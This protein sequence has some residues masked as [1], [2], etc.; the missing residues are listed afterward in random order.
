V[1]QRVILQAG[2]S[3][4][5]VPYATGGGGAPGEADWTTAL[6]QLLEE[7]LT[8]WDIKVDCVG[9]WLVTRNG[10][11]TELD[12]PLE[13]TTDADLFVSIHYDAP[14]RR[15][16]VWDA[17]GC[18]ADRATLDPRAADADRFIRIWERIY[19]AGTGIGLD[20]YRGEN[21]PNT[22]NYYAFR[23]TTERT[24]GVI[25]EH[26]CGSPV[27]VG[28]YPA[29]DDATYLREH[30]ADVADADASAILEYLGLSVPA[31]PP[32]PPIEDDMACQEELAAM[33]ADRNFNF[34]LKMAYEGKLREPL[35]HKTKRGKSTRYVAVSEAEIQAAVTAA[36]EG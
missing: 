16:G 6:V 32:T 12:P 18:F 34:R 20:P 13:A 19:P 28:E 14:T 10:V 25:I 21:Q 24:P 23:A 4:V 17:S 8:A 11:L 1:T 5:Y 27:P 22:D 15:S 7:R 33:T 35:Y 30:I 36:Q 26:G 2:H 29:G 9:A 3:S 31:P